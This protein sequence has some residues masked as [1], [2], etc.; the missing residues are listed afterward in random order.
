MKPLYYN[1]NTINYEENNQLDLL[2]PGHTNGIVR[3][4][5]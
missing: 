5:N 1:N 4:M 2:R 3:K